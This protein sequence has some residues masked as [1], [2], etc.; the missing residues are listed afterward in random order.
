[1]TALDHLYAAMLKA[2]GVQYVNVVSSPAF[3]AAFTSY[4]DCDVEPFGAPGGS[5]RCA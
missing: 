3:V 2:W 4:E 1:M 5:D